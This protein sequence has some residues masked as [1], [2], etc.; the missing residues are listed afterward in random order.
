MYFLAR[1]KKPTN[2]KRRKVVLTKKN[3]TI[4]A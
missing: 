3:K 4:N 2:T 1:I